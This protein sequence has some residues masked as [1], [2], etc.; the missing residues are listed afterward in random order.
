M[1][2]KI[3]SV[4]LVALAFTITSCSKKDDS[5]QTSLIDSKLQLKGQIDS[6]EISI[7]DGDAS[8]KVTTDYMVGKPPFSDIYNYKYFITFETKDG[9]VI[10][11][12]K[13][14]IDVKKNDLPTESQFNYLFRKGK[15]PFSQEELVIEYSDGRGNNMGTFQ[16]STATKTYPNNSFE[17]I[18]Y[19]YTGNAN[20][21]SCR[22]VAKIS[23]TLYNSFADQKEIELK[24][25]TVVWEVT[26]TL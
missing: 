1:L 10:T 9:K 5:N 16:W 8:S 22:V 18:D 25:V 14:I 12:R 2:R 7:V 21:S 15:Y 26:H 3:G 24:D 11:L 17:I 4:I 20:I 13:G 23:C 6:K 19:K